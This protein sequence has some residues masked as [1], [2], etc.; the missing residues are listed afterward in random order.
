MKILLTG[1]DGQL[2]KQIIKHKP[3]GIEL[4]ETRRNI[5]DLYNLDDCFQFVINKRP[6]WIINCGAYTNVEN[7]DLENEIALRVNAYAPM[8]FSKALLETGGKILQI[9]TDFV[10]NGEKSK[11]YSTKEKKSP[12]NTYG[13]TKAKGEGNEDIDVV[14][15]NLSSASCNRRYEGDLT[16]L[17]KRQY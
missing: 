8:T 15:V 10:F 5:L 11:P 2:A 4:I 1:S 14:S 7:A 9:S 3:K 13:K 16:M 12:I 6:D 17:E